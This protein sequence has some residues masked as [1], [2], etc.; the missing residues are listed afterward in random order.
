MAERTAG[1]AAEGARA[2]GPDLEAV[3]A[4]LAAMADPAV[5]RVNERHGDRHAVNLTALRAFA[6]RIGTRQ[7]LARALWATDD[8]AARLLAL[9]VCRPRAFEYGELDAMLRA[10][11]T[12][13]V[14]DW[15][16]SYAAQKS[17][18]TEALRAAWLADPAPGVA[19]A[20]WA[21][22]AR[23]VA[24]KP[25]GL[26]LPALLD[27]I[28]AQMAEAPE[29]LQWAMNT[30]LA[31]I[32]IEHPAHR[33]RATAIGERL[34]VLADYPVSRGCTSPYAPVWIAEA[35]RRRTAS[36]SGRAAS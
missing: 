7:D 30:C 36:D 25:D 34:G 14:G 19:A 23:R 13:K 17:P 27:A 1:G 3:M 20:G 2:P 10:V 9:L 26:D 31:Q 8:S 24:K 18:H 16:V 22:T 28:E 11:R 21:L 33:E 12:P 29:R 5:L 35:V 4:E 15:L 6:K 32:G